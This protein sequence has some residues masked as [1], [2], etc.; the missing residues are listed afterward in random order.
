MCSKTVEPMRCHEEKCSKDRKMRHPADGQA[1]K[2]FDRIHFDFSLE[3]CNVRLGITSDKFNL[4]IS[5]SICHSTW[6]FMMVVYNFPPWLCKK[7]ENTMLS[8]LIHGPYSPG[9][10]IDIY[11]QH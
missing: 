8:L 9:N 6:S 11:L 2:H 4:F 10:D 7:A 5:M 1:W 3:P